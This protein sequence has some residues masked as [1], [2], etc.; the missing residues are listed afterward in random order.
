MNVSDLL[1]S[2]IRMGVPIA[3]GAALAWLAK[4]LGVVS[5]GADATAW[6]T[7]VAIAAYY[8]VVRLAEARWP[9]MGA[10]LGIP[11]APQY[12]APLTPPPNGR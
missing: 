8:A 12:K 3:V 11:R 2:Y 6:A 1:V 10:L 5:G 4:H 7:S 9:W